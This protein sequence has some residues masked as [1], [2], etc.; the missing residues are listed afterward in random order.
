L[1]PGSHGPGF[2]CL[3]RRF[4][5]RTVLIDVDVIVEA[6]FYGIKVNVPDQIA[7]QGREAMLKW[8]QENVG[9]VDDAMPSS[10]E[11]YGVKEVTGVDIY[12]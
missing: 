12:G 9:V 10:T 5:V 2:R 7:D 6:T 4:I 3:E 11:T 1:E 8:A